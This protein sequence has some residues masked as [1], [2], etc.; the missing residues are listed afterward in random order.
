MDKT[1]GAKIAF[2]AGWI[3]AAVVAFQSLWYVNTDD[4]NIATV[5]VLAVYFLSMFKATRRFTEAAK[6]FPEARKAWKAARG[7]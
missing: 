4:P 6:M 3:L 5:L 1:M 2:V 7:N